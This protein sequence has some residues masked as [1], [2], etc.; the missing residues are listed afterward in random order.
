MRHH[1]QSLK[2][3]EAVNGTKSIKIERKT[4]ALLID[5]PR[6]GEETLQLR[7][8]ITYIDEVAWKDYSLRTEQ[9]FIAAKSL[10]DASSSAHRHRR[11][12][13]RSL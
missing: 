6:A 7:K 1:G 4:I 8:P 9:S 3:K 5:E 10:G 11:G 12:W 2:A 13:Y